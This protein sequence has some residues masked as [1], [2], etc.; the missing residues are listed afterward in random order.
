MGFFWFFFLPRG[1]EACLSS[2][3]HSL[4]I[5]P[6]GYDGDAGFRRQPIVM[7]TGRSIH[8]GGPVPLL[9]HGCQQRGVRL[10]GQLHVHTRP[11]RHS[12]VCLNDFKSYR[13]LI[14]FLNSLFFV[15]V[16]IG[17]FNNSCCVS[18]PAVFLWRCSARTWRGRSSPELFMDASIYLLAQPQGTSVYP[19]VLSS[20]PVALFNLTALYQK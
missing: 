4:W 6:R 19:S 7:A 11:T 13:L 3:F 12:H 5:R 1:T 8:S 9:L 14:R 17:A 20:S 2:H 16:A 18:L 15:C 10:P